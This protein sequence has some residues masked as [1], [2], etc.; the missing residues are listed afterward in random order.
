[1]DRPEAS[2]LAICDFGA[3]RGPGDV[4]AALISLNMKLDWRT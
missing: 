4:Q 1:M 2:D 3:G